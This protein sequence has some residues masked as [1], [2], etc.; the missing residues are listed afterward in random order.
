MIAVKMQYWC[1]SGYFD[2]KGGTKLFKAETKEELFLK[3]LKENYRI[4]NNA[5]EECLDS[6]WRFMDDDWQ[7]QDEYES[8]WANLDPDYRDELR[9]KA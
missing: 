8:W 7:I 3:I 5:S 6:G 9:R 4:Q 1:E 2:H